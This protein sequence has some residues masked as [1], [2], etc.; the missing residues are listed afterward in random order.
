VP[1]SVRAPTPGWPLP[2]GDTAKDWQ[3]FGVGES[4]QRVQ[5]NTRA[6]TAIEIVESCEAREAEIYSALTKR[7]KFMGIF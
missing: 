5:A 6:E 2:P 4:G 7:K 1:K 3:G